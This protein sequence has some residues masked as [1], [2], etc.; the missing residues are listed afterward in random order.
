M[1]SFVLESYTHAGANDYNNHGDIVENLNNGQ[2]SGS[3]GTG[4]QKSVHT[5]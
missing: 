3:Y 4:A 1:P 2:D 5:L